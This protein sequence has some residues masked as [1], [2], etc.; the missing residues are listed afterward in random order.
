[1]A[2]LILT[3]KGGVKIEI[4]IKLGCNNNSILSYKDET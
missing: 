4:L 3:L 2:A 1:M